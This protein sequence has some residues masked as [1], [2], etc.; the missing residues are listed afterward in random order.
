MLNFGI[1][2]IFYK[3]AIL[4]CNPTDSPK[5]ECDCSSDNFKYLVYELHHLV[6]MTNFM[7]TQYGIPVPKPYQAILDQFYNSGFFRQAYCPVKEPSVASV[8]IGKPNET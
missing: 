8:Y 4:L 1:L 7:L 2:I 3:I 5:E 6:S